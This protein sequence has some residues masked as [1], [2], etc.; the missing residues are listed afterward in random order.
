MTVAQTDVAEIPMHSFRR[1]VTL[2]ALVIGAAAMFVMALVILL[3]WFV[4]LWNLPLWACILIGCAIASGL[5]PVFWFVLRRFSDRNFRFSVRAMLLVIAVC[6]VVLATIGTRMQES[7]RQQRALRQISQFGGYVDYDGNPNRLVKQF[8]FDPFAEVRWM[9]VRGDGVLPALIKYESEFTGLE[10]LAFSSQVTDAGLECIPELHGFHKLDTA[11][12]LNTQLTDA[13]MQRLSNWKNLRVLNLNGCARI[14]DHGLT[15]LIALEHLEKLMLVREGSG[16]LH[17]TDA[18]LTHLGKISRLKSLYLIGV[19]V[20]NDGLER[21]HSLVNLESIFI[22][23]TQVTGEG[24]DR[25]RLALPNC[26]IDTDVTTTSR[27]TLQ[28]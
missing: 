26:A 5:F 12:F 2:L 24:I 21:L 27:K 20:T 19:P 17:I 18:G 7:W 6:G 3:L 25:L 1:R 14:S 8:G 4:H 28:L 16:K 11:D 13:G 22:R 10:T 23:R 15:H 9:V